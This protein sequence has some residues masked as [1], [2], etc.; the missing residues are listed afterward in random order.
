MISIPQIGWFSYINMINLIVW[1]GVFELTALIMVPAFY[2]YTW[3]KISLCTDETKPKMTDR[4]SI[5]E[6]YM[7]YLKRNR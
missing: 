3:E 7:G 4:K 1:H 6:G 5:K 2:I